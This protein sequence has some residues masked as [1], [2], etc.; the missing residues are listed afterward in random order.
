VNEGAR[1]APVGPSAP[2]LASERCM[3]SADAPPTLL[4]RFPAT[5]PAVRPPPGAAGLDRRE[6][7]AARG[8]GAG[9]LRRMPRTPD[10][11]GRATLPPPPPATVGEVSGV[12]LGPP[13]A[14]K[15]F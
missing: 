11:E 9:L 10:D 14:R 5:A 2:A 7:E 8:A 1:P 3:G 15:M 4:P 13:M 6:A 12:G